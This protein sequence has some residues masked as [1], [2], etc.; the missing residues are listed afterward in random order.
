[1]Q[2][3]LHVIYR[4]GKQLQEEAKSVQFL[5]S[6]W[7]MFFHNQLERN[8]NALGVENFHVAITFATQTTSIS[9]RISQNPSPIDVDRVYKRNVQRDAVQALGTTKITT[10][11]FREVYFTLYDESD[12]ARRFSRQSRSDLPSRSCLYDAS[13]SSY[14]RSKFPRCNIAIGNS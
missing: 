1:M 14:R 2:C 10:F 8:P 6:S 7:A 11:H 13:I 9:R 5:I 4:L 3:K 12:V